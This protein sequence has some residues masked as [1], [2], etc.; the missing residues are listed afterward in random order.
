VE[1]ARLLHRAMTC[2]HTLIA[3]GEKA[4]TE[5]EVDS[6]VESL[7]KSSQAVSYRLAPTAA[8]GVDGAGL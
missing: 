4:P 7:R 8:R 3:P 2:S 5:V 6:P 1:F